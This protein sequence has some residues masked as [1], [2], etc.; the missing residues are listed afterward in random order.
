MKGTFSYP[1]YTTFKPICKPRFTNPTVHSKIIR[2]HEENG[3]AFQRSHFRQFYHNLLTFFYGRRARL[4]A[5]RHRSD[6]AAGNTLSCTKA[7]DIAETRVR[8]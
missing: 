6:I 3:R 2:L 4:Q 1:H 5:P 8:T 7:Y